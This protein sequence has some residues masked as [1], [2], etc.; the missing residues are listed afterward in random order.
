[1]FLL[2]KAKI[3]ILSYKNRD[4]CSVLQEQK[5]SQDQNFAGINGEQ[6]YLVFCLIRAETNILSYKN[7]D[8]CS[9]LQEQK[10]SQKQNFG[11]INGEQNYP[12][13]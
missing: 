3:N 2:I 7:R 12:T 11:G 5:T 8:R 4:R 9:V 10:T 13:F 1:M 6:N